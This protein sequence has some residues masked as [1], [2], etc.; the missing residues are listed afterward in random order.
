MLQ[1]IQSEDAATLLKDTGFPSLFSNNTNQQHILF[2]PLSL[3]NHA[4]DAPFGFR[5]LPDT[6]SKDVLPGS[7]KWHKSVTLKA[8]KAF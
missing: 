4:C 5:V 3:V 7:L 1:P 6:L 8:M 2:G